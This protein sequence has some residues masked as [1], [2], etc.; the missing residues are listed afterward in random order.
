MHVVQK[1]ATNSLRIVF[2]GNCMFLVRSRRSSTSVSS[3]L[4]PSTVARS[5][6][7]E[8][9]QELPTTK[10]KLVVDL[11]LEKV[12]NILYSANYGFRTMGP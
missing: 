8:V 11:K 5:Q 7:P 3:V 6:P 9:A 1:Y 12:H 2:A 4:T 10:Q